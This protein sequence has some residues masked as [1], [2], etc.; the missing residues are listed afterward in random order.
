MYMY[1][2][3]CCC[4][5]AL[6]L[7][8]TQILESSRLFSFGE[9]ISQKTLQQQYFDMLIGLVTGD[10]LETPTYNAKLGV[11]TSQL[12][13]QRYSESLRNIGG[14]WPVYGFTMVGV[15]RTK[16]LLTM[17]EDVV[18]MNVSGAFVECGTWRGGQSIFARLVL[19][20]LGQH[21]RMVFVADSFEGLPKSTLRE[22]ATID[23]KSEYLE[24]SLES[25]QH[26]FKKF[27]ARALQNVMFLHGFFSDTLYLWRQTIGPI[28][29]L[30]LDGDMYE[31]CMDILVALFENVEIGG[32]F[33]IDDWSPNF[34]CR[35][36]IIEFFNYHQ[37][38]TDSIKSIGMSGYFQKTKNFQVGPQFVIDYKSRKVTPPTALNEKIFIRRKANEFKRFCSLD[39]HSNNS[40]CQSQRYDD[41]DVTVEQQRI[42]LHR[43]QKESY[44]SKHAPLKF[45]IRHKQQ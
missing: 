44:H 35:I 34:P 24:V 2:C 43:K 18:V 19:Q 32:W 36:A 31:S 16:R 23:W 5:V 11:P 10:I 22:D 6:I 7:L 9:C 21:D 26:N 41:D 38:P 27:G 39:F 33:F 28:A 8:I 42:P 45:K 12:T 20:S 4:R 30:R 15:A 3:C 37:Y 29:I 25:V 1:Y 13:E 17:L 14:D 40:L